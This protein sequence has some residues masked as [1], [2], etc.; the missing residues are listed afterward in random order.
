MAEAVKDFL[1]A[2]AL[3][4]VIALSAMAED[5]DRRAPAHLP[6]APQAASAP[7][8]AIHADRNDA[9]REGGQQGS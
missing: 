2:L 6:R 1:L 9:Q 5:Q 3:L 7:V 8:L 4:A